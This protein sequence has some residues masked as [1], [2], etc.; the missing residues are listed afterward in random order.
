MRAKNPLPF[1]AA[2]ALM[3]LALP[4]AA[5]PQDTA[6]PVAEV[7]AAD[8]A[9]AVAAAE[10]EQAAALLAAQQAAEAAAAEEAAREAERARVM[11]G[12]PKAEDS[13]G[14]GRTLQE[15]ISVNLIDLSALR[16][17]AEAQP[18]REVV[19]MSLAEAV[20][21]A[22]AHNPDI[23]VTS[24]EPL[25]ADADAYSASGEFD[26]VLQGS[27]N[28]TESSALASQEIRAFVGGVS[29][30]ETKGLNITG[31]VGGK[32]RYGTQ[33]GVTATM[34]RQATTFGGLTNEYNTQ[35]AITLT[36]PLLRGFGVKFNT[37][38]I[39]AAKNVRAITEAQLSLSVL[40]AV[41]EVIKAYWDLTGALDAVSVRE[42]SL[43]NAERLLKINETR[44]EIGTAADIEVLQAKAGVAAR[45]SD[46]VSASSRASDAADVLKQAL[47]MRDGDYFSKVMI[48]PTDRPNP[49]DGQGFDF[50]AF[51]EGVD[52]S[53]KLAMEKRPELRMSDLELENADLELFRARK[54]MLP[55]F[56]LKATYG[57]GGRNRFLGE[58]VS[59]IFEKQ[60]DVY[61]IGVEGAVAIGNRAARGQ[62]LKAR[63][64]KRQAE[65]RRRQTELALM[66]AVHIAARN[67][68][69]NKILI[70]STKQAV[71]LQ[72]ANVIAE[73]KRLRLGVTTSFQ[74][75]RVQEDLTAARTQELQARIMY[76]RALVDLQTAEGTLL[77]HY[78]VE[79]TPPAPQKPVAWSE[80][81]FSNF[82]D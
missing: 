81:V 66:A 51:E 56:D 54:D 65:D 7:E 50:S 5:L 1:L 29:S 36:Q 57:Q 68:M 76:E 16:R 53:V 59:G 3:A 6:E 70:E 11:E 82:E 41:S 10:A 80:A 72:E 60:E 38:R 19:K 18:G 52:R 25:K 27:I 9:A 32:L 15:E 17:A 30:L 28:Y 8:V 67:V 2:L 62:H 55:Q 35:V 37:V 74:V 49:E 44:R 20:Q 61:S 69:T 77:E 24:S 13:L 46:L 73:E 4:P 21:T 79:V 31:G 23:I 47:G 45:Q 43:R 58:S 14:S 22:L 34:D 42:E 48:I 33:Y 64:S 75:L 78:G 12:L 26:P 63:I 71:R 40:Q 39:E